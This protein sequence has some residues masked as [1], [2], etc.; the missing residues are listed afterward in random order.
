MENWSYLL[1]CAQEN[2]KSK[3]GDWVRD[4]FCHLV[5]SSAPLEAVTHD[6]VYCLKV[7]ADCADSILDVR[8][9]K[10]WANLDKIRAEL[11]T[12][13][14]IATY[15]KYF[16]KPGWANATQNKPKMEK[17]VVI[18][19]NSLDNAILARTQRHERYCSN[20]SAAPWS[21]E[22]LDFLEPD[23]GGYNADELLD[24][25][26]FHRVKASDGDAAIA[27]VRTAVANV[28]H[29][30]PGYEGFLNMYSERDSAN[31][32][33]VGNAGAGTFH[34]WVSIY[35]VENARTIVDKLHN[36]PSVF[37]T[38]TMIS[39]VG[40]LQLCR[41]C[42][43][44]GHKSTSTECPLR[45]FRVRVDSDVPINAAFLANMR[46][47]TGAV[48]G[49]S[50]TRKGSYAPKKFAHLVYEDPMSRNV[51]AA[52][53]AWLFTGTGRLSC[54]PKYGNL[55]CCERCG[56][57]DSDCT[58]DSQLQVHRR[59][60]TTRCPA[61]PE[62]RASDSSLPGRHGQ[63]APCTIRWATERKCWVERGTMVWTDTFE[64]ELCDKFDGLSTSTGADIRRSRFHAPT[65]PSSTSSTASPMQGSDQSFADPDSVQEGPAPRSH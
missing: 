13:N 41:A 9:G 55:A 22:Y 48:D 40:E 42:T 39:G 57:L 47:A 37:K 50:G 16:R 20:P 60:D 17:Y 23:K 46:S 65:N 3:P 15:M 54:L 62:Y 11:Q 4:F 49:Y 59:G 35:G 63:F 53:L 29:G 10:E 51:A 5:E 1:K 30:K 6:R 31:A 2:L 52:T 32:V 27:K 36:K 43:E 44:H 38:P 21:L 58:S 19:F 28:L 26:K 7:R 61:A 64:D 8:G 34:V 14:A 45:R 24:K 18:A 56:Q 33:A 12:S 25:L